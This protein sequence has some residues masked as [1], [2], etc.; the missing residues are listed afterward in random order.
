MKLP[1]LINGAKGEG[2]EVQGT[3]FFR[4]PRIG[5]PSCRT[6]LRLPVA[7]TTQTGATHPVIF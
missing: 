7:L 5:C 4:R 1:P 6:C 2:H 3:R